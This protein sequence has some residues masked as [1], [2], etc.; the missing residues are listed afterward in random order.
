MKKHLFD[1]DGKL[2]NFVN[3]YVNDDDIKH[4]DKEQ[5]RVSAKDVISIIP[6]VA[7]GADQ[8]G[9]GRSRSSRSSA[10]AGTSSCPRSPWRASRSCATRSVLVVGAGGLGSPVLSYLAA[11]GCRHA[12]HRGFRHRG[13]HQPPAPDHLLHLRRRQAEAARPRRQDPGHEPRCESRTRTR[14]A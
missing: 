14:H 13:L 1:D 9:T 6:S 2:R 7:G 5:T 12:G 3:V 11:A 10:T 8:T 4:L